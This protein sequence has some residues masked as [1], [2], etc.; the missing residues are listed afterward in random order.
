[1]LGRFFGEL[2]SDGE[3]YSIYRFQMLAWTVALVVVFLADVYDDLDMPSFGPELLYL[4]GLSSGTFV[5]HRMPEVLRDH[6]RADLGA[7]QN[8]FGSVISNLATTSENLSASRS[9]IRDTDYARETAELTRAQIL[10]QAGTAMVAQANQV[11]QSV[12]TLLQG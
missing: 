2:V 12:L 5:A 7:I 9:R 10:Q 6:A 11:P 8:R 3:G 1:M 4:L